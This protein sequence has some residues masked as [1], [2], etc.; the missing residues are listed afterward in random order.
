MNHPHQMATSHPLTARYQI[1][2][3][4]T[5]L[6][7]QNQRVK[8]SPSIKFPSSSHL[9]SLHTPSESR[10]Q[11]V[12]AVSMKTPPSAKNGSTRIIARQRSI[13][14]VRGGWHPGRRG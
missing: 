9:Y 3:M 6:Q 1:L 5:K 2:Q 13:W 10:Y 14:K 4:T 7:V 12:R 11:S 8:P